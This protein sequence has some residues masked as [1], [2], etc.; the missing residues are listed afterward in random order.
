MESNKIEAEF[1]YN[2]FK[3][4]SAYSFKYWSN[5]GLHSVEGKGS[6]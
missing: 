2:G 5:Y 3:P 4:L 6:F 1:L